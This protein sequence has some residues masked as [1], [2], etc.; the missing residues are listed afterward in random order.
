MSDRALFGITRGTRVLYR[1]INPWVVA[2]FLAAIVCLGFVDTGAAQAQDA[3]YRDF[4]FG[5][6]NSV[7]APTGEKP[8]SKLWFN[9]G[10]WWGSLFNREAG[11]YHIY[12]FDW[13][14][15][16]WSDTGTPLDTRNSSKADTL[17]DGQHLYVATAVPSSTASTDSNAYVLRYSYDAATK[18]YARDPGFPV[19]VGAGSIEAIVLDKDTTGKLW[20]TYT[21]GDQA[22]RQVYVNRSLSD[23][24]SWG[25]PFVLPVAGTTV[26]PDDISSVIAFDSKIGV[27]WSNQSDGTFYFATHDDGASDDA[28][29]GG[30]AARGPGFADDHLNLASLE[31]DSAGRVFAAVKTS[32]GD[33]ASPNA[34][35]PL[36]WLLVLGTDGTWK[37]PTV[38]GRVQD[39]H[40]RPIVKIDQTNRKLYVF[41]TAPVTG[42]TIY[43]KQAN[44]SDRISFPEGRGTPFIQSST[45]TP[46]NNVT[47]TKQNLSSATGLL[48]LA[49]ENPSTTSTSR[50]YWHNTIELVPPSVALSG[51]ADGARVSGGVTISADASDNKGVER[52]EFLVDGAVVGTDRDAPYSVSWDSA[53]VADGQATISA[54]AVDTAGNAKTSTSR[55]VAVDNTPPAVASVSPANG[56]RRVS[57][58]ANVTATFSE[59]M[60]PGTLTTSTVRLV[61][62]GTTTPVPATVSYDPATR[63]VILNPANNLR[64]GATYTATVVGGENG[65]KD[66]TGSPLA[67]D[68]AWSFK[69]RR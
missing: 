7:S 13:D 54:R 45:G 55:T 21:Q 12:R 29:Q 43:Y 38:F 15:Q 53:T 25:E 16:T 36:I 24:A 37:Q 27:M 57:P 23:D 31:A 34:N 32:L 63:R 10:I 65:A 39:D 60:D 11:E 3:G 58:A 1:R 67:N 64:R 26:T 50:F 8:Q 30:V 49:S 69:I 6:N 5:V 68:R 4:D 47:S 40:T 17:W 33:G 59:E 62:S 61:R 41:A 48:L 14:T 46:I 2:A 22:S 18:S 20:V 9:D 42:G 66:R 52:V 35:A 19:V 56:A 51:P 44:L 28:W